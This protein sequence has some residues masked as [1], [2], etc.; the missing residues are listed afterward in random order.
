MTRDETTFDDQPVAAFPIS[1]AGRKT[2]YTLVERGH[3]HHEGDTPIKNLLGHGMG[4]G[5]LGDSNEEDDDAE[6]TGGWATY[7][8][9]NQIAGACGK[10]HQDTDVIVALDYRRYGALNKV[11]KYCG[12]KVRIT[13]GDKTIEATVADACPTCLNHN[14]LDLSE[15]AFKK[16][17]VTV[18]E[19]MKPITWKFID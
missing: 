10:V 13:S 2:N 1:G 19:G 4:L 9:Q 11:S 17:G 5:I 6:F 18:Q 8:T 3:D 14:C 12:K 15:G 7:F 16:L